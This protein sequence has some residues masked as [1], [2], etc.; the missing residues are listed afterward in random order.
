M[1]GKLNKMKDRSTII[2]I[3]V[4]VVACFGLAF[5]EKA[6]A[7]P[8]PTGTTNGNTVDGFNAL[9][10][11]NLTSS[12]NSAFG[13]FS[14]GFN[15]TGEFN[16]AVGAGSLDLNGSSGGGGNSN[17]A[18]GA[19]A[20]LLN[21]T[22]GFNT[23]VGDAALLNNDSPLS[24][25]PGSATNNVAVG[26]EALF[27]NINASDN[28]AVGT[29]AL[30]FNDGFGDNSAV[31][32]TA[33]GVDALFNN[34]D[35]DSNT[36]V[37]AFALLN[38]NTDFTVPESGVSNDAF[39]RDAL[40]ANTTGSF[41]EA[42]GVNALG[43]NLTSNQNVAI[44]D[45]AML[46]YTGPSGSHAGGNTAVGGVAL[47]GLVD[48][49]LDTALGIGAGSA[50]TDSETNN[51]WIGDLG[52]GGDTNVIAIGALAATGTPYANCFIGGIATQTQVADGTTV[53]QVTVRFADGRLG[54][55][56]V[57]P[58][59]PGGS[60]PQGAPRGNSAAP[61]PHS[62]LPQPPARPQFQAM[63]NDKVEKLETGAAQQQKEIETQRKQIEIL[64]AQLKEQAAQIQ[65]V[66]AQLEVSKPAPQVVV[67]KP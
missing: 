15:M 60:A 65:K 28:T 42:F 13:W 19:A 63:L 44:G 12:F 64:T 7:D 8:D 30:L 51:I 4:S 34:V 11:G 9:F 58:S 45:D 27:S 32:N 43:A 41:N 1:K 49:T 67:N 36:A 47:S 14:Q 59:S 56:C 2:T 33:V 37:G 40:A 55:D 38:N 35:G 31:Q 18:V 25:S 26:V 39:G 24:I 52:F 10:F 23:A 46:S 17:T 48:G 53:C 16:T 20:M 66:S 3:I 57:N 21:T 5:G 6:P 54:V 22:A 61:R 50:V 62:A 29:N